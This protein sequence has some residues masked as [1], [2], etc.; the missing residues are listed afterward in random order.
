MG[1]Y[2]Y[3]MENR[4]RQVM[5]NGNMETV[6]PFKFKQMYKS[7]HRDHVVID[8]AMEKFEDLQPK[9]FILGKFEE[10]NAIYANPNA[11]YWIDAT[12]FL[13]KEHCGYIVK[14]KKELFCE[15]ID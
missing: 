13:G 6:Y 11:G 1:I 9:Y 8:R 10:G 2:L 4:P 15:Q 5:I 7:N 12:D 3:A 14:R